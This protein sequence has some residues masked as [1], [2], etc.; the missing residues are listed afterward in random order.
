MLQ[1]RSEFGNRGRSGPV[2][3]VGGRHARADALDQ[4]SGECSFL[5]TADDNDSHSQ[6]ADRPTGDGSKPSDRPTLRRPQRRRMHGQRG[7][8]SLASRRRTIRDGS[9]SLDIAADRLD[10]PAIAC[11]SRHVAARA[12]QHDVVCQCR[13]LTGRLQPDT[14]RCPG[15]QRHQAG[16]EQPLQVDHEV[17]LPRP[18][19]TQQSGEGS[20]SSAALVGQPFVEERVPVHQIGEVVADD[21]GDRRRRPPRSQTF[22]HRQRLDDVPQRTRFDDADPPRLTGRQHASVK[23]GGH[24]G[25]LE[26]VRGTVIRRNRPPGGGRSYAAPRQDGKIILKRDRWMRLRPA[27]NRSVAPQL[28]E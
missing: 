15:R 13:S 6:L 27:T 11:M 28:L 5:R 16:S 3:D 4:R 9:W 21:P 17:E 7:E 22:E 2:G 24:A 14:Q 23:P 1:Q 26:S 8:G 20:C 18:E 19:L 12:G 10:Q 25:R